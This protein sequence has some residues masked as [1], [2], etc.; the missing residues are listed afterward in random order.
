LLAS[1][2]TPNLEDQDISLSLACPLHPVRHG[3]PCQ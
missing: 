1:S 2:Q 3:S